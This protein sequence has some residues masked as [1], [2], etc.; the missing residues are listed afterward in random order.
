MN[1]ISLVGGKDGHFRAQELVEFALVLPILAVILFGAVDLGR[2]FFGGIT[3]ANVAR[4]GA[5]HGVDIDWDGLA[6][7]SDGYDLVVDAAE[8]E[9]QGSGLDPALL[10][11]TADCGACNEGSTL[12]VTATYD[13]D[14][15]LA[16]LLP[17]FPNTIQ[18][19]ARMRI[20]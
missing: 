13:F 4:E 6:F 12:A 11:V 17:S 14:L 1:N 10:T 7:L 5:R 19:S 18:R 15:I 3:I 2:V 16:G 8:R 20:P 9:A